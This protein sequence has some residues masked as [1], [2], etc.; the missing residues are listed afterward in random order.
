MTMKAKI[1]DLWI[2]FVLFMRSISNGK[3]SHLGGLGPTDKVYSNDQ[4]RKMNPRFYY[5]NEH[6]RAKGPHSG[7]GF[8][9]PNIKE[10]W[11]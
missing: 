1:F 2:W 10:R 5:A 7:A 9:K 6:S 4:L 8:I 3:G 11:R